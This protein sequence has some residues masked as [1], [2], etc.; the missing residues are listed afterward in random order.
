[1]SEGVQKKDLKIAKKIYHQIKI[2]LLAIDIVWKAVE[3]TFLFMCLVGIYI[4]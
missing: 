4:N 2:N 3:R 1:M